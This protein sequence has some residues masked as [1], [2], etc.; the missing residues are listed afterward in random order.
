MSP[1]PAIRYNG[2]TIAFGLMTYENEASDDQ[3]AP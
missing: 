1:M 3:R 2:E